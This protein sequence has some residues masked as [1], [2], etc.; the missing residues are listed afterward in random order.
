MPPKS[1]EAKLTRSQNRE[2]GL[3]LSWSRTL[4]GNIEVS[5]R[6]EVSQPGSPE[7]PAG[8][9]SQAAAVDREEA[10]AEVQV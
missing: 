3:E 7:V 1:T 6:P 8:T 2:Q 5:S 10:A 9:V 4:G